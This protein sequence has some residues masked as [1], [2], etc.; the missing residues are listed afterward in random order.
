MKIKRIVIQNYKSI[1]NQSLDGFT[2]V[3]MLF[4]HNNSGKSNILKFI[5]LIFMPKISSD[6]TTIDTSRMTG[7]IQM[8][9]KQ[10]SPFWDGLI[11]NHSYIFRNNDWKTPITFE[12]DIEVP[13][14]IFK[15]LGEIYAALEVTYLDAEQVKVTIKGSISGLDY[16]TS[17]IKLDEALI[18]NRSIYKRTPS[19]V[20][21]ESAPDTD[22]Y[23]FKTN[24]YTIL[25]SVLNIFSNSVLLLD[26]DR[27]FKGEKED[28]KVEELNHSNF[29]NWF[30][31]ISLHPERY[32]EFLRILN[33]MAQ[34]NPTGDAQFNNNEQNSPF[35]SLSFEFSRVKDEIQI[36]LKNKSENRFPLENF[37]TGIQ[38]VL[39]IL[40]KISEKKPRIILIEEMELNLSPKYQL[41]LIKHLLVN[42]IEVPTCNLKQ[43]FFTTHSPLLCYRSD[44]Q[45]HNVVIDK[46]GETKANKL[47]ESRK[48]ITDF[49]PEEIKK[50]LIEQKVGIK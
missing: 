43:L 22:E 46:K 39:Y 37:G 35:R 5:E 25:S 10:L 21:F 42:L 26:N 3:N 20:Y 13:K 40:S 38:Q 28:T 19:E 9:D 11:E 34:Y 33:E 4:G 16:Y 1:K 17:Q 44:F 7:N 36:M 31:N 29:K 30:H 48:E 47:G 14:T 12:V 50:L 49:Y 6:T 8:P 2:N 32:E 41:E 24:G 27:Y 23:G 18:Q 45:I 15:V